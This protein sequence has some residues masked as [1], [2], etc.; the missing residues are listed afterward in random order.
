MVVVR[1]VEHWVG[2]KAAAGTGS[3]TGDVW[4][5]ATGERQ[6]VV[7]LADAQDVDTAVRAA[8]DAFEQ[9][10]RSSLSAR[11][12]VLFAFRELVNSHAEAL[13]EI[14]SDEH[15]KVVSDARGEVQRGLEVVE[16]ACGIPHLLKE[17]GRASC[18]ERV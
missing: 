15:G 7:R 18:R 6:A 5:P 9:W 2:G 16:F 3:R 13:A 8:A 1:T 14:V 10:S 12:T 4:N 11:A 17:I